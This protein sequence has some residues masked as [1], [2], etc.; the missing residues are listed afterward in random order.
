VRRFTL[1]NAVAVLSALAIVLAALAGWQAMRH[2]ALDR[3]Q[4]A[5]VARADSLASAL[6]RARA[7]DSTL[8]NALDSAIR[9]IRSLRESAGAARRDGEQL[10][11][12]EMRLDGIRQRVAP[13]LDQRSPL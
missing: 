1:R 3:Q 2:H 5:I 7:D 11:L 9:E 6:S 13:L 4:E 8:R 10:D 12:I